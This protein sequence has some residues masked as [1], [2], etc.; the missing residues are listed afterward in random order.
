M[1]S[2]EKHKGGSSSGEED[3]DESYSIDDRQA[4]SQGSSNN[5]AE[6]GAEYDEEVSS[7]G[8]NA[9]KGGS[10]TS[11]T[12]SSEDSED[13]EVL[14]DNKTSS[15]T[16]SGSSDSTPQD[17]E[18]G[19]K[20]S[21]A[22]DFESSGTE[23]SVYTSSR[24]KTVHSKPTST[25]LSMGNLNAATPTLPMPSTPLPSAQ[26]VGCAGGTNASSSY[27]SAPTTANHATYFS[28]LDSR[29]CFAAVLFLA[30]GLL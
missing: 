1:A 5:K 10:G 24:L 17:T 21:G 4:T 29:A 25:P 12:S 14:E 16:D 23:G 18:E 3:S 20:D 9:R 2:R 27:C 13:P 26:P 30:I 28:K 15:S 7:T 8:T 19:T 22:A 6:G 11:E